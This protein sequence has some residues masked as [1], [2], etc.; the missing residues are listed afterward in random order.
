MGNPRSGSWVG[1]STR[2]IL[3]SRRP[4]RPA[5]L[6]VCVRL[7]PR[8]RPSSSVIAATR[9]GSIRGDCSC[10]AGSGTSSATT[11][12]DDE[13]R[14]FR[15]DR[16]DGGAPASPSARP[17]PS[18]VRRRSI[19]ARRSRRPETDRPGPRRLRRRQVSIERFALQLRCGR[20]ARTASCS[21]APMV[22]SS[23]SCRRPTSMRSGPGCSA[24]CSTPSCSVHPTFAPMS[25]TG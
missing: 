4:A 3:R 2:S 25:S 20:S 15:V 5:R 7:W 19:R 11:A 18:S 24:C 12:I 21:G 16:F 9:A 8:G 22:Q 6:P 17:T 14:T 1:P 23:S 13:Q 10:A